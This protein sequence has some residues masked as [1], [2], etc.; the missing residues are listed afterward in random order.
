MRNINTNRVRYNSN[1][2][3]YTLSLKKVIIYELKYKYNKSSLNTAIGKWKKTN[4]ELYKSHKSEYNRHFNN[5][6]YAGYTF[7][8]NDRIVEFIK[9]L[10]KNKKL[11]FSVY[12]KYQRTKHTIVVKESPEE[13]KSKYLLFEKWQEGF[14]YKDGKGNTLY[15]YHDV[16][17]LI[18]QLIDG[19]VKLVYSK[20]NSFILN[21]LGINFKSIMPKTIKEKLREA[22][23]RGKIKLIDY[24]FKSPKIASFSGGKDSAWMIIEA[25]NRGMDF[26][27]IVYA[28]TTLDFPDMNSYIDKFEKYVGQEIVR[29]KP[30]KTFDELFHTEFGSGKNEGKIRGYPFVVG[31]GCWIKRDLKLKQIEEFKRKLKGDYIDCIGIAYDEPKRY[32]S[33][34]VGEQLA[35]LYE[36]KITEQM[37]RDNLEKIGMLNPL[38]Y[39]FKRLGCWMC[40]K[41]P[42]TA[43]YSLYKYY[44]ELWDTLKYYESLDWKPFRPDGYVSEI[45]EKFKKNPN[46]YDIWREQIKFDF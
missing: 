3:K 20:I 15:D 36:W 14:S 5:L 12:K 37:C 32:E 26:E 19:K 31:Q 28:D 41:Q 35:P 8:E 2:R 39:K 43:L 45:E 44:P 27:H 33:I 23:K 7:N 42:L 9:Y 30:D 40:T 46:K 11:G 16:L 1:T 10:R 29:L 6:I 25:L 24:C 4:K 34:K 38:Y 13:L 18:K 22:I 21:R 17:S